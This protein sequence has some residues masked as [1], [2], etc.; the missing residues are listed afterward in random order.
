MRLASDLASIP[1]TPSFSLS[2]SSAP[3]SSCP[4]APSWDKESGAEVVRD[5]GPSPHVV[6]ILDYF[7]EE[8]GFL[9]KSK[10]TWY[11]HPGRLSG[12]VTFL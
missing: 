6:D 12:G 1:I 9:L 2:R 8:S 4:F 10:D 11:F 7:T 3:R 5:F